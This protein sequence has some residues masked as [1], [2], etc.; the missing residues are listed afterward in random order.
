MSDAAKQYVTAL[1]HPQIKSGARDLLDAIAHLIPEGQ[2]TTPDIAMKDLATLARQHRRTTWKWMGVLVDLGLVKVV[3]GGQGLTARYEL[4][5]VSGA[6]PFTEAPL[7]L[8]GAAA[9]RRPREKMA[10]DQTPG[11]FD[12]PEPDEQTTRYLWRSITSTG[13]YLWRSI[14]SWLRLNLWRSIT[15]TEQTVINLWRSITST[16]LVTQHVAIDHKLELPLGGIGATTKYPDLAPDPDVVAK[17]VVVDARAREPADLFLDWF[18]QTYPTVHHGAVCLVPRARD[19]I[20]VR[21]LLQRPLT[22]V[23]HLQ[24]M[25]RYLWGVTTDGVKGSNRWWIAEVVTVRDVFVLHRKVN[26]LDL[27]VRR[28][29]REEAAATSDVWTEIL[30]LVEVKVDR[31]TFHTWF[32]DTSLRQEAGGAIAVLVPSDIHAAWL[33]KHYR[34]IVDAA[35]T[36]VRPG[37]RVIFEPVDTR[38]K[39][40]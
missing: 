40:G 19:V 3:D 24:D 14:T 31:N 26:F 29:Q 4:V 22:D 6:R 2:A 13:S 27:E 36:D 12:Q 8:I 1:T 10:P 32:K 25:T 21:E 38:R 16:S 35:V 37:A 20:L 18:E 34:A 15:S 28:Q 5:Q 30:R 9:R 23:A 17:L 11:L 33:E 39:F 7:P